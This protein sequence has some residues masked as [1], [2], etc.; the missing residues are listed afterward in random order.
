MGVYEIDCQL[1]DEQGDAA[2][3]QI[4]LQGYICRHARGESVRVHEQALLQFHFLQNV[5]EWQVPVPDVYSKMYVRREIAQGPA[6]E[7]RPEVYRYLHFE[8]RAVSKY[9]LA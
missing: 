8:E 3:S 7:H 6:T 4:V 5:T 9:W 2:D 1:L